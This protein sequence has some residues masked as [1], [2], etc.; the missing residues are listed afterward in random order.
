MITKAKPISKNFFVNVAWAIACAP[1]DCIEAYVES[2][3]P[4]P[5]PPRKTPVTRLEKQLEAVYQM[6][7]M[8]AKGQSKS[9]IVTGAPGLGKTRTIRQA[10][11]D[12]RLVEGKHFRIVKGAITPK[13]LYRALYE[14]NGQILVLDDADEVLSNRNAQNILK[15]AL[16]S[17]DP[18]MI[19][20]ETYRTSIDNGVMSLFIGDRVHRVPD[21]PGTFQYR[22]RMIFVSNIPLKDFPEALQSRSYLLE[23]DAPFQEKIEHICQVIEDMTPIPVA[24]L[25]VTGWEV[26]RKDKAARIAM[27]EFFVLHG[28]ELKEVSVRTLEKAEALQKAYPNGWQ[29]LALN[30]L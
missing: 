8:L 3:Q 23:V 27:K 19:S 16:D 1:H 6:A 14:T 25:G 9:M 5:I 15:T 7:G 18:R 21:L 24:I 22:G 28:K 2:K 17:N 10:L 30:S 20:W 4:K 29:K 26:E 12:A 11:T 13:A